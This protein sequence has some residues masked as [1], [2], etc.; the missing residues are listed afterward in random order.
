MKKITLIG[1]L[2]LAM[3]SSPA[4]AIEVAPRISDKEIVERLTRLEE[5]QKNILRE[6][7]K[8][9]E[10]ID[11]RFESI[12]KRF[13]SIDKRFDQLVNVFIGIV[14]A[15][16]GIVAVTI[17]FAI[18]DRRSALTPAIRKSTEL[19]ER[20]KRLERVLREYAHKEP[21]LAEILRQVGML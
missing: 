2:I 12:D 4:L 1:A 6:I 18:W 17:G 19:E 13:E 20:E 9:F 14:A 16:A 3:A 11:K 8:R 15:F 7:D 21:R 10:S 5:G